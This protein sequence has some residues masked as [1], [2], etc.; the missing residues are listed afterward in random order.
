M[1]KEGQ[2][3]QFFSQ[4]YRMLP[5]RVRFSITGEKMILKVLVLLLICY[6]LGAIPFGLIWVKLFTG[7]DIR[8]VASGRTGGTNAMRAGGPWVGLLTGLGDIFKGFATFWVVQAFGITDAWIRVAAAL[9]AILGHNY[10]FFLLE[11]NELG[12]LRLRGGAGGATAV[13]GAMALWLPSA[14][15]IIPLGFLIYMLIGYASVTTLSIAFFATVIFL[16]RVLVGAPGA[17]WAYVVY[18]LLAWLILVYALRP[19]LKRLR[20]G[21][22]RVVG[23]RAAR[24]RKQQ[25]PPSSPE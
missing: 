3:K 15:I 9:V 4:P 11:R 12:K 24:Q 8:Q 25:T 21:N 20:E 22:E 23:L 14:F 2:A 18:G 6:F 7:K 17:H 10:S 13:G 1:C 19:N 5:L 16:V